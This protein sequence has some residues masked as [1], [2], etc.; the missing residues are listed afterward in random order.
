[1]SLRSKIPIRSI[2]ILLGLS[3]V[4]PLTLWN[5]PQVQEWRKSATGKPANLVVDTANPG[6]EI[7]H[8]LWQNFAQGGEE[9]KDMVGPIVNQVKDLSPKIIRIDHLFDHHVKVNG[10]QYDFSQLDTVV[11]SILQTG[12]K[13]MLSLSYMPHSLSKDNE[14]TSEPK[15]WSQWRRLITATV[16]RY[17]GRGEFNID[18]I[19]YEVWNEP[20]LFGNWHYGKK[21]N[22]LT[23]YQQTVTAAMSASNVNSFKIGGPATTGFYANWI[24]ALFNFCDKNKLRIDFVSWHRYT[25][26]IEDYHADFEKLNQIL[27]N[28]PDF[29]SIER[30][31]TESGPDSENSPW[32][33]NNL[34]AIHTIASS[35]N[36]LGKVHRVFSFELKDGP[37]PAGK[38]YWGRWGLMTHESKGL[39][40]KPRYYAFQF[41]NQ[42]AGKRLPV[43]G[44]GSWVS[45]IAVKDSSLIRV[46]INNYDISN[47]H[48]ETVPIALQNMSPGTYQMTT[49]N[50]LGKT[51]S[52]QV[53]VSGTSLNTNAIM[54]PNSAVIIE[55]QKISN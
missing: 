38:Q 30:I 21:K 14:V 52:K 32:Y 45:S 4:L 13:P 47:K 44:E 24:K 54:T 48:Y 41:L 9:S 1:M 11:N 39:T 40:L 26:R 17:S 6:A 27:T 36:L 7:S 20:D 43:E 50:F 25:K 46:L 12:A 34:S 35:I 15:D 19:Y 55:W 5:L 53:V 18:N 2:V 29:F 8:N 33:D 31:I 22:Y 16:S 42:M 28:Y 49:K 51:S 3:I 10:D 37:D 23:L